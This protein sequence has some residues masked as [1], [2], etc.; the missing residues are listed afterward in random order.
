MRT[1]AVGMLVALAVV[2]AVGCTEKK[3][4]LNTADDFSAARL[5]GPSPSLLRYLSPEEKDA[6]EKVGDRVVDEPD[7]MADSSLH[8]GD[9]GYG[10]DDGLG[11][12]DND[13]EET[14]SEKTAKASV[15]LLGVGITLGALVAPFFLY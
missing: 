10:E 15:S 12:E 5:G 11:V 2:V 4:R 3:T 14:L 8:P 7:D 9:E 13:G 6:L 1:T